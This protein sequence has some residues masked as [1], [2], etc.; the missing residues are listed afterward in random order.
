MRVLI[1]G[2]NYDPEPVGIGPYTA[3]VAEALA[4]A[5]HDVEMVTAKPY[6][7]QWRTR[8]GW[9]RGWRAD[10]RAGVRVTRCPIYVPRR[11]GALGRLLHH[12]SFAL[13]ALVPVWRAGGR[14]PDVV[15]AVAPSLLSVPVARLG[16]WRADGPLWVH[17]QDLEVEAAFA[18]GLVA[19]GTAPSWARAIERRLLGGAALV[20]TISPPM[21][22]KLRARVAAPV[23]ELRNWASDAFRPTE[24][25]VATYRA[26]WALGTRH[27]ALYSGNIAAKQGI[28]ILIDAARRLA[29][30]DDIVF[31]ICGEG[32]NRVALEQAAAGM[33]NVQLHPLQPAEAMGDL[34]ALASVHLLPQLPGAADLVLPSKLANMLGSGRPVVATA[35]AGTGLHAEVD[36]CGVAVPPGDAAALATAVAALIDDPARSAALGAAASERA[37]TRWARGPLLAAFVSTAEALAAAPPSR[38]SGGA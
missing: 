12:A 34:L 27:V 26:R 18:T 24:G 23:V 35:A 38:R 16:A 21:A 2:I 20:S 3:G 37:A 10:R 33:A 36:R 28:G 15:L 22:A 17:V 14:R 1:L 13:S 7:P 30:R 31:V 8:R 25:G 11:P 9:G 5:G 19:G 6:Y 29:T 4:A 32:P